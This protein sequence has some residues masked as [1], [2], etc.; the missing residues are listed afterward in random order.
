MH[1]GD[2]MTTR[3][4]QLTGMTCLFALT[5]G[6]VLAEG[7]A[8]RPPGVS[9]DEAWGKL[10][11]GNA[12]F[13]SG[14]STC[15]VDQAGVRASLANGQKPHAVVLTCSDSRVPPEILFDQG[16]GEIFVI[17]VAG[18]VADPMVLGSIEYAVEHLGT[19]LVLVLGHE[20]C[21]A[22]TAAATAGHRPTGN[23]GSVLSA[24]A[25]AVRKA[26]Q[27]AHGTDTAA[28][29]E[30]AANE[31]ALSVAHDMPR[32]SKVVGRL[33]KAGKLKVLAAKYDLDDGRV[34]LLESPGAKNP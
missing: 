28:L 8:E 20:R 3:F 21:G 19:P 15:R 16:L 4:F 31:N 27:H 34:S 30:D 11:E 22:V 24:I 23:V 17:R 26:K 2:A 12:R 9:P 6:T 33:V 25:P 10:L 7:A 18:N 14:H 29:V 1:K 32:L 5:A 13:A